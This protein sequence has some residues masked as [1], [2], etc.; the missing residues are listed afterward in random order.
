MR[1]ELYIHNKTYCYQFLVKLTDIFFRLNI[2]G[3]IIYPQ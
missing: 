3:F 2:N 1:F